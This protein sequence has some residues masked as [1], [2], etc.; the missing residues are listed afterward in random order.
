MI[1]L[2]PIDQSNFL[3]AF[4]LTLKEGQEAYVS[5]PIRSLAQAYVYRNQCTPFGVYADEHMVGYV[6]VIFD[7]DERTY[8][9]WHLMIDQAFQGQGYGR[10]ALTE[11]IAYCRRKPFGQSGT[12]LLTCSPENAVA[13]HLYESVG[14]APTGRSDDEKAE[15]SLTI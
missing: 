3:D 6:M 10:Q 7:D 1:A 4:H 5:H 14:F 8:N 2:K 9:I 15:L 13:Y 12:L 11:A